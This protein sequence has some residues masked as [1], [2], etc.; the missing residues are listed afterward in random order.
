[1]PDEKQSK[2][3]EENSTWPEKGLEITLGINLALSV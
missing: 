2:E 3:R 1:L